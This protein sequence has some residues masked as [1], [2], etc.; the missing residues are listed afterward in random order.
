MPPKI[1]LIGEKFGRLTVIEEIPE[2]TKDHRILYL[3]ECE[4]GKT[5]SVRAKDLR[6][7]NTNSCGCYQLDRVKEVCTGVP[8]SEEVKQKISKN[9]IDNGVAVGGK[10]PMFDNTHTPEARKRI[11]DAHAGKPLTAEHRAK[12]LHNTPR[13]AECHLWKGG[14]TPV[15]DRIRHSSLMKNWRNAVFARDN[16]KCQS[17]GQHG[18]ALQ[19]HHIHPFAANRNSLLIFDV[20]NGITL[21]KDCHD[22]TKGTELD[23]T[24]IFEA[25][26]QHGGL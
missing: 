1:D 19:A 3:C 25:M 10:N 12:I 14:I 11:G 5:I 8:R 2:R 16:F 20:N 23:Y 7:G 24:Q 17:C 22:G 21:C 6:S 9:R 26:I 15:N 4:C 13:G 18:G